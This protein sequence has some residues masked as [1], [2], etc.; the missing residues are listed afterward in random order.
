M[1]ALIG[2][3]H[4]AA[5]TIDP[6]D[7]VRFRPCIDEESRNGVRVTGQGVQL[8]FQIY[9]YN[10]VQIRLS[11]GLT[12]GKK[13]GV[14]RKREIIVISIHPGRFIKERSKHGRGRGT[15]AKEFSLVD[16]VNR[17]QR[18]RVPENKGRLEILIDSRID[19]ARIRPPRSDRGIGT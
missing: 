4:A 16:E 13:I 6:K 19:L 3:H 5:P 11:T 10:L 15:V 1:E 12:R 7:V 2:E 18:L 14:E 8:H 9:V 17:S